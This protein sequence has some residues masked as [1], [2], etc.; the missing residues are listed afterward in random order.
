VGYR[1]SIFWDGHARALEDMVLGA[2]KHSAVIDM[3]DEDL[4]K[5]LQSFPEYQP[6]FHREFGHPATAEAF[7]RALAAFQRSL[8]SKDTPFD[9]FAQGE[10]QAIS[11]AARRGYILFR[12]K[13]NCI[14]C[15]SGPDFTDEA[16]RRIGVGW[17]GTKYKDLGRGKV[18]GHR[19][20]DGLFRVPPLRELV[21]TAPYM[22]DGSL[23]TLQE[24]VDFYD[25]GGPKGL[26]TD[27]K[28]PLKLT[29]EEK[30]DLVAFLRSLSSSQPPRVAGQ[31]RYSE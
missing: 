31:T 3:T 14:T 22:H 10:E 19:G 21:W 18:L 30:H 4:S 8:L 6:L 24:V 13:A 5:R 27:L 15:H 12:D 25:R 28:G 29:S 20:A 2:I 23:K 26:T 9:R 16:F 1:K 11:A 7:A 17:D